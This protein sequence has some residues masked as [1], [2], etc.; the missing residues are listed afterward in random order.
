[1]RRLVGS[2]V[3]GG[4]VAVLVGLSLAA[5]SFALPP[6]RAPRRAAAREADDAVARAME[7]EAGEAAGDDDAADRAAADDDAPDDAVAA[8]AK[9]RPGVKQIEAPEPRDEALEDPEAARRAQFGAFPPLPFPGMAIPGFPQGAFPFVPPG[10]GAAAGN[11]A[12]AA[13][14]FGAAQQFGFSGVIVSGNAVPGGNGFVVRTF[15]IG[16]D[17]AVKEVPQ[18]EPPAADR[19]Q[20]EPG[21]AKANAKPKDAAERA[22]GKAKAPAARDDKARGA[23]APRAKQGAKGPRADAQAE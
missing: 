17:G 5:E 13:A 23:K 4:T 19:G 1:M 12:G 8:P 10:A 11:G 15:Q 6:A 22:P 14:G 21:K 18:P 2:V 20:R 9:G 3:G 7:G 16:P